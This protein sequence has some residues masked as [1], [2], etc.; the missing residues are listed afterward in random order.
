MLGHGALG[1]LALGQLPPLPLS[2]SLRPGS[3]SGH[4]WLNFVPEPPYGVKPNK[5]FRPIWDRPQAAKLE[6]RPAVV[7]QS[8]PL[9]PPSIFVQP[10]S[11]LPSTGAAPFGLPDFNNLMPPD[12]GLGQRV[13]NDAQD[14]KDLKDV[15][16]AFGV[17][18]TIKGPDSVN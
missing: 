14:M 9:P 12:H 8:V 10:E 17:L 2:P 3:G 15:I 16:D 11:V 13:Q 1:Q 6:M 7:P 18:A 5:P 4:H